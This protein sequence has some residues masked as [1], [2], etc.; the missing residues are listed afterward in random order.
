MLNFLWAGMILAGILFAAFTGRIPQ[1]TNA[2]ID[3]S[4]EAITLC[5]TMMGVMALWVGLMEIA[6]KAGIMDALSAR[7]R[8]VIRFLFP[9]LPAGHPS[10]PHILTNLIANFLGLG[11]AATPAGLKAME[12]LARLEEER[13]AGRL[14]GAV[15]KRGVAGNEMCTFHFFPA[16]DPGKCDRLPQPVRQRGPGSHRGS[17][18]PGHHCEHCSGGG[19]LPSDGPAQQGFLTFPYLCTFCEFSFISTAFIDIF[20]KSY[21]TELCTKE[22][23]S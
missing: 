15:R 10:E 3:S 8:P 13:R 19:L 9:R 4:K 14:P 21:Y 20:H 18:D 16:A 6:Q 5:V 17:R 22:T 1:I 11:W 7:L 23:A 12:E 2:A